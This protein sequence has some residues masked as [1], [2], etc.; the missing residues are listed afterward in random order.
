MKIF[1][2]RIAM[3]FALLS[4]TT[5]GFQ[6][7]AQPCS[8]D[9]ENPTECDISVE[10]KLT[11][12]GQVTIYSGTVP[13]NST[14]SVPHLTGPTISPCN[15]VGCDIEIILNGTSVYNS[16][17]AMS[18]PQKYCAPQSSCPGGATD[19]G[20]SIDNVDFTNNEIAASLDDSAC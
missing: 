10:L 9:F 6:A 16:A 13:A 14:G 4:F 2:T 19:R 20:I 11:C 8:W 1:T 18:L 7:M 17:A 3:L 5:M 15:H 12:N